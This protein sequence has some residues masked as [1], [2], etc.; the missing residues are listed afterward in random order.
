AGLLALH[1]PAR[2]RSPLPANFSGPVLVG[3]SA[4]VIANTL[5]AY[6][7][8]PA[9]SILLA[10]AGVG[11]LVAGFVL[12]REVVHRYTGFGLLGFVLVR[13]FAVDLNQT[14]LAIRALVFAVLGAIL[15]GV[16]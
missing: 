3:G 5:L 13:V 12:R 11:Y 6:A 2:D 1:P 15:L 10:V 4:L 7:N 16:G 9:V 8:G 14:D